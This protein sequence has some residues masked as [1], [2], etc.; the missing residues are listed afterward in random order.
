MDF[1][2]WSKA[3]MSMAKLLLNKHHPNASNF[4]DS[5]VYIL[6]RAKEAIDCPTNQVQS[7]VEVEVE[8]KIA[9]NPQTNG[10]IRARNSFNDVISDFFWCLQSKKNEKL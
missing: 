8:N 9:G 7:C 5:L 1:V 3:Q 2:T 4:D 6:P 10:I